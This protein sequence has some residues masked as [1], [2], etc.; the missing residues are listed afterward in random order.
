MKFIILT[1]NQLNINHRPPNKGGC[2]NPPKIFLK[3]AFSFCPINCTKHFNILSNHFY[4]LYASFDAY[5]VKLWGVVWVIK[6]NGRGGLVKS[7]DSYFFHFFKYL[8]RY[9]HMLQTCYV[10]VNHHF[11]TAKYPAKIP[12]F[13]NFLGKI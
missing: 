12:C 1:F 6:E 8:A 2:C 9:M 10:D 4:I 5:E 7:H 11:L 13:Y 3:T